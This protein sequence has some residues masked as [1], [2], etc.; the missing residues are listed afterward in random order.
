MAPQGLPYLIAYKDTDIGS[1]DADGF[2]Q[3]LSRVNKLV[4]RNPL[5]LYY[6]F[7]LYN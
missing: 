4:L 5:F 6:N 7:V 3:Q 2:V 1:K